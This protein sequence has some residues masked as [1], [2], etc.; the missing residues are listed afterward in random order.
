MRRCLVIFF[1]ILLAITH[2]AYKLR[3]GDTIA[4]E[5]FGQSAFSRTVKVAFDGTIPYPYAGN[6]KVEGL[7][8]DQVKSIIEQTVA[9]FIKDP[10]VTVYIVDY[11]PM[12]VYLQGALNRVFDIS[13]HRELTLSQ[14]FTILGLSADAQI[15]YENVQLKRADSI[16]TINMLPFFYEGRVEND[17]VLQE[18][19][20]VYLPPLRHTQLVQISG[21]YT[22]IA[23]YDP[24]LTLRTLLLNLGP[25][26]EKTA[27]IEN[28]YLTMNGKTIAIN[29]EEVLS[30]KVDYPLS[31]GAFLYIPKRSERYVY[32]TGFVP[33]PGLKTFNVDEPQTLALALA[34][35]GGISKDQEK[36]IEKITITTLDGKVQEYDR[37]ILSDPARIM[38]PNG[39]IVNVVKHE[40]FK[41]YLVG[42][43]KAGIITLEPD[44]PKTLAGLLTKIGGIA[45][46]QRKWIESVKINGKSVDLSKAESYTLNNGDTVEIKKFEEFYVYVQGVVNQK[47]KISFE[48][49]EP[50]TLKTLINKIGLPN[51]DVENEG[52]A[53][54]NNTLEVKLKDVIYNDKDVPLS[55][56]DTVLVYYE[57][58]LVHIIGLE[59]VTSLQLSYYEPKNLS[60][61]FKKLVSQPET[62]ESV[63]LLRNGKLTEFEPEKLV[64]GESNQSL[65]KH[66]TLIFKKADVNA[67]YLVGDVSSY[68]TFALNEQI[69]IRRVLAKVGLSDLRKI[70]KITDSDTVIDFTS[71]TPIRR[72]AVLYVE[73]KKP[74][75][76]TAMGY[77]RNTG[78]VEFDYY[79]PADLQTLF[80]KLG[81]LIV[82]PELY[83]TSDKVLII[84]DG[85]LVA[86]YDAEK[87]F[88]GIENAPLKDGDFVYVTQKEPNQVYVFGKGVPNGLVKFTQG[89]AFDLRTL[90]GKLGGIKEGISNKI[91]VITNEKVEQIQWDEYTNVALTNNSILLFDVDKENYI[92][93]INAA[94][95]PNMVYSDRSLSLYEILTKVGINKNYRK[96][97]LTRGTQKQIIELKDLSEARSYEVRPG[98]VV[99]VL[100]VPQNF[101]YVLGE[102]NRP[103]IVQLTEGTTVLQA[104]I[105]AG[106]FTQK[107]APSSVWLYRG[108]VN[109]KAERINL[110]GAIGGGRI[111]YNPVL[112]SGDIVF[113]PSDVFKSAL[114]WVPVITTLID[115]YNK[116]SGLFK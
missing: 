78:R 7:T 30:G 108:G 25:L 33:E 23:K 12:N 71:D 95:T 28:S 114:E 84:R 107:A 91:T 112:E 61:V 41:V 1:I 98:D 111:E 83:Y 104:I 106:Y 48:P 37:T 105:E 100:D 38:V 79:E 82:G 75:F 103:G 58:F 2:F 72:G 59:G 35:A 22:R 50:R 45:T 69:T 116:V 18:G 115:F 43:Y 24:G 73:L 90:I 10:V 65:E 80:A 47:G 54:L 17:P 40:E 81:G 13:T 21:A 44:E 3:V 9:K 20:V 64:Y 8:I 86:Q 14:L 51:S 52:I 26:D 19:D 15:D 67:V 87:I 60:Y 56:G 16:Q 53:I 99:R 109:G 42:D 66:D 11:A 31:P 113:V 101:A 62:I 6:I 27:V 97:E 77:I 34:K 68:V 96:I 70:E 94:G 63:V 57:P 89:E 32:V 5:V 88:K 46:D 74:I 85:T 92:Y 55:L 4:I 29:L 49:Q 36:W 76:V 39:A 93:V 110:A 102:V